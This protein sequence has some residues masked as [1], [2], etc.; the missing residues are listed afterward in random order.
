MNYDENNQ[1]LGYTIY[2]KSETI[3]FQTI[4]QIMDCS[5][6]NLFHLLKEYKIK[7]KSVF[8]GQFLYD[9]NEIEDTLFENEI[10][11]KGMREIFKES[12]NTSS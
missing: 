12:K 10:I 3:D 9:R 6:S 2:N 8:K 5:K 1:L 11:L 4:L 7:P